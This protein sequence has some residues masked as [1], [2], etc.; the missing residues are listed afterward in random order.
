MPPIVLMGSPG[1]VTPSPIVEMPPSPAANQVLI[2]EFPC[3][4]IEGVVL[5]IEDLMD[6]DRAIVD[7]D[8]G[9]TDIGEGDL[10]EDCYFAEGAVEVRRR[11]FLLVAKG[12]RGLVRCT[13]LLLVVCVCVCPA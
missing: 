9:D 7:D 1:T 2:V 13:S 5:N 4:T 3:E 11:M 10:D 6:D 12:C 8:D